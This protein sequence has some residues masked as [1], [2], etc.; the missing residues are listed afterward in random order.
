MSNY[1][2]KFVKK[3][4]SPNLD[5]CIKFHFGTQSRLEPKAK[6]Q[7]FH[8][9]IISNQLSICKAGIRTCYGKVVKAPN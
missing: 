7:C 5:S 6:Y 2:H 8:T 4:K 9:I 1:L 3:C